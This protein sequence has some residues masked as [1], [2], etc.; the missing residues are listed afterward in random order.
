MRITGQGASRLG[1]ARAAAARPGAPPAGTPAP[2]L[3]APPPPPTPPPAAGTV[4]RPEVIEELPSSSVTRSGHAV[5]PRRAGTSRRD[6]SGGV[7]ER[8][9][10]VEVPLDPRHAAV[11]V[12]AV[13]VN[14]APR[15]LAAG[16]PVKAALGACCR[17][18]REPELV[19]AAVAVARAQADGRPAPD[20]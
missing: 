7:V 17:D 12:A 10:V 11:A 16:A 14:V 9:V 18:E 5:G 8:P 1:R 20:S 19:L 2:P 13:A 3:T 15:P 4:T 6:S